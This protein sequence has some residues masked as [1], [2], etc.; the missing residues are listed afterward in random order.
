MDRKLTSAVSYLRTRYQSMLVVIRVQ[1][2]FYFQARVLLSYCHNCII[3]TGR[4]HVHV[5]PYASHVCVSNLHVHNVEQL[6][7]PYPG[8]YVYNIYI[9]IL[10]IA[11]QIDVSILFWNGIYP[12][13]Q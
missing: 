6:Y 3:L 8:Y 13:F 10:I 7:L 2:F 9:T 12:M 1:Y 5:G 4:N 11:L